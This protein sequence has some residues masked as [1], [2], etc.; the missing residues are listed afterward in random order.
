MGLLDA[1][2]LIVRPRASLLTARSCDIADGD[3]G[4]V[5]AIVGGSQKLEVRDEERR[6][7]ASIDRPWVL[8]Y[9]RV[10][11]SESGGSRLG[12]V[13]R[14][15]WFGRSRYEVR[16]D[17]GPVGGVLAPL[18][19][20]ALAYEFRLGTQVVAHVGRR[21]GFPFR[22][23]TYTVDLAEGATRTGRLLAL[24]CALAVDKEL[25]RRRAYMLFWAAIYIPLLVLNR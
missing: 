10:D 2:R 8:F 16:D 4:S 17:L 5:G 19:W 1:P 14:T 7:L 15:G 6:A 24:S 18:K 22:T 21:F 11:I 13:I 12:T 25:Y 20:P 9:T 3:G 23:G